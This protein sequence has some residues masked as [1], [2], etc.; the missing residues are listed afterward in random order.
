M[1]TNEVPSSIP[2]L[3]GL[4]AAPPCPAAVPTLSHSSLGSFAVATPLNTILF[5][6]IST[7]PHPTELPKQQQNQKN[8]NLRTLSI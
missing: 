3:V 5:N 8:N 6:S 1:A 2:H 7:S 4:G